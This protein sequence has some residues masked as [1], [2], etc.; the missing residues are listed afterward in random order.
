MPRTLSTNWQSPRSKRRERDL[1][2]FE[3]PEFSYETPLM[4]KAVTARPASSPPASCAERSTVNDAQSLKEPVPRPCCAFHPN[5]QPIGNQAL[6]INDAAPHFYGEN[7]YP[8]PEKSG[9][10]YACRGGFVDLG[11]SRDWLDWTGYL[12]VHAKALLP[13]GGTFELTCEFGSTRTVQFK[14]QER[15]SA[16]T[17]SVSTSRSASPISSPSGMR[18]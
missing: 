15:E 2:D 11:H 12:A 13:A 17:R 6:D 3:E 16:A 14:A 4:A 5:L 18:S 10:I 7:K 1:E 8:H 9:F